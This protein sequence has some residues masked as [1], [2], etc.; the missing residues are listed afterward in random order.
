MLPSGG[1]YLDDL[2]PEEMDPELI[3]LYL[4]DNRRY[5]TIA[6]LHTSWKYFL[7]NMA[8]WIQKLFSTYDRQWIPILHG[9]SDL[10]IGWK[11]IIDH[12]WGTT[13]WWCYRVLRVLQ[14]IVAQRCQ[15]S[16][17]HKLWTCCHLSTVDSNS[18]IGCRV[19]LCHLQWLVQ[20]SMFIVLLS[21]EIFFVLTF[22][23]I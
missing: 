19:C 22:N 2:Q 8:L 4:Y 12:H 13:G 14:P 9:P 5:F 11:C 18:L 6:C 1:I 10:R 20:F 23:F 15:C 7:S 17:V 21:G 16:Y 3:G